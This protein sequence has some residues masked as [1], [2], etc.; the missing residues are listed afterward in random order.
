MLALG[1]EIGGTKLQVG[2]GTAD[3]PHLRALARGMV[4]PAA[5]AAGI[6]A[7][8]PELVDRALAEAG[9]TLADVDRVGIGFGGPVDSRRGVVLKSFQVAGWDEFPLR[10]WAG[11]QWG[12]PVSLQNDAGAAALAEARHGAGRGSDRVFYVTIGSGIGGGWVAQG[13]LDEG[14][15]LGAAEIGHG[16]LPQPASGEPAELEQLCSGWAIGRR[17]REAAQREPSGMAELAGSVAAIDARTVYAAAEQGDAV[18]QRILQETC[19]TLGIALANVVALLHPQRI[20]MGGGVSL[21][22]PLFWEPLRAEVRRWSIPMLADSVAVLP[23]ELGETVVV[24][25]AL[26]LEPAG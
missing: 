20:V 12:K 7:A 16:W 3:S 22:G 24:I 18:A 25:G 15:G 26:C 21:M 4:E 2:V 17:A 9:C 1:V 10:D 19:R 14:Q 5:G 6:R 11:Q 23:A 13:Q 8:L